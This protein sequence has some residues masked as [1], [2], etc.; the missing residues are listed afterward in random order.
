M[1]QHS[2]AEQFLHTSIKSF[3]CSLNAKDRLAPSTTNPCCM[4][5]S[6]LNLRTDR[7][8]VKKKKEHNMR[9]GGYIYTHKIK[10][11]VCC[12][13][14][15]LLSAESHLPPGQYAELLSTL[16]IR[17]LLQELQDVHGSVEVATGQAYTDCRLMFVPCQHPYFDSCESQSL[18]G[19]L[20]L[21]LKSRDTRKR[22]NKHFGLQGNADK[23]WVTWWNWSN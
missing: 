20:D 7:E 11:H 23:V 15:S 9:S 10:Q 3:S 21:V 2:T 8:K 14:T 17:V 18:N 12:Q 4:T 1:R 16:V 13:I 5:W 19:L 22:E 6:S